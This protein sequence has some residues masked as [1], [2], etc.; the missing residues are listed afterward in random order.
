[1]IRETSYTPYPSKQNEC[2]FHFL[3]SLI[4]LKYYDLHKK[5]SNDCHLPGV[6]RDP[7]S[8]YHGVC[9][10]SL[11]LYTYGASDILY[12]YLRRLARTYVGRGYKG[13]HPDS[14]SRGL[15][16]HWQFNDR[17]RVICILKTSLYVIFY[18]ANLW[19][20]KWVHNIGATFKETEI[21]RS[22]YSI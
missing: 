3:G 11:H 10:Y 4:F 5:C 21:Y 18:G 7:T 12:W 8:I 15:Q 9:Q 20:T 1:M 6:S 2:P 19:F 16:C 13:T 14:T 22:W 17:L